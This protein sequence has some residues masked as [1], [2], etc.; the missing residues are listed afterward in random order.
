MARRVV[1][2]DLGFKKIKRDL[3]NFSNSTV[4]IGIQQGDVTHVQSRHGDIQKAGILIANYAAENEFGTRKIPQRSFMRTA[5]DENLNRINRIIQIQ[6]GR[7]IDQTITVKQALGEIGQAVTG[8]VQTKIAQIR[9]P[10]NS[11]ETI[12][13]KRSTKPLID[14]GQMIASIRYTITKRKRP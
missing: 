5:F 4:L 9:S 1:D 6:A 11:P 8:M 3:K 2:T 13:R 7:I 14:F 10:P 12:K